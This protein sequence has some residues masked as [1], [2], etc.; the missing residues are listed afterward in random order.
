VIDDTP[1][2][3]SP[4]GRSKKVGTA[5]PPAIFSVSISVIHKQYIIH[6]YAYMHQEDTYNFAA[7]MDTEST[8]VNNWSLKKR[9]RLTR[10]SGRATISCDLKSSQPLSTAVDSSDDYKVAEGIAVEWV[11]EGKKGVQVVYDLEEE[12][13]NPIEEDNSHPVN[14][15]HSPPVLP[16]APPPTPPPAA[17]PTYPSIPSYQ[18]A[19]PPPL[20]DWSLFSGYQAGFTGTAR[21]RT[22]QAPQLYCQLPTI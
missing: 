7:Y 6:Q 9:L 10:K 22:L 16:S 1:D 14:K 12:G 13:E 21:P 2:P 17:P 18:Y 8:K 5:K 20:Y 11:N 19:L 4:Y 3:V 15:S